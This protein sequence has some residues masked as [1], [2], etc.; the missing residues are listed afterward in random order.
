MPFFTRTAVAIAGLAMVALAY[1]AAATAQA[2]PESRIAIIDYQHIQKNSTAM[3]GIQKQIE[4]RRLF[5]QE[6]IS[7]Q[8]QQLRATDQ[9]LV[10]Q[11]SVL[12]A[13]AFAIKRREFETKVAQVQRQVQDRKREL[14]EAFE[15][16]MNQVQLV[17]KEIIADLSRQKKFNLV[18]SRQQIIFSENSLNISEDIVT[19]LN[20]RLPQVQI[21]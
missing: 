7:I 1:T 2:L 10:N 11:R 3:L 20:E 4:Q 6:E 5:Y 9:E 17:V 14:D 15:H 12:S 16:G 18:L 21:P 13:D 8:E 19:L